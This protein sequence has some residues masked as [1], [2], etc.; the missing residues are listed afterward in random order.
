MPRILAQQMPQLAMWRVVVGGGMMVGLCEDTPPSTTTR[1]VTSCG[2]CC[3]KI[4]GIR[5]IRSK[6]AKG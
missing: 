5:I 6:T 1:H 3:A 2:I 4:R